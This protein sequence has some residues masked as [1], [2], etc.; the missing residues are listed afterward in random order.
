MIEKSLIN[1]VLDSNPDDIIPGYS[2]SELLEFKRLKD[3]RFVDIE[4]T[5]WKACYFFQTLSQDIKDAVYELI[6]PGE[7]VLS[8]DV[9]DIYFFAEDDD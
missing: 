3:G 7:K 9:K 1:R 4:D 8:I 5:G 2:L 6:Y